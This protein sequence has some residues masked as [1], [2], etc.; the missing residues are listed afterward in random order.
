M[1]QGLSGSAATA[2]GSRVPAMVGINAVL[3]AAVVA[4]AI[5]LNS[6]QPQQQT[7]GRNLGQGQG[8]GEMRGMG[9]GAVGQA[10]GSV[11]SGEGE[12]PL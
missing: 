10:Y 5:R 6:R 8:W 1:C 7:R 12:S 3:V 4:L 11:A 9:N 2:R